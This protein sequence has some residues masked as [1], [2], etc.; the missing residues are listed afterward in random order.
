MAIALPPFC[1]SKYTL[2][3]TSGGG[4]DCEPPLPPTAAENAGEAIIV[5]T[6]FGV[7]GVFILF[8]GIRAF[9]RCRRMRHSR[10]LSSR[11]EQ[12]PAYSLSTLPEYSTAMVVGSLNLAAGDSVALALLAQTLLQP[13]TAALVHRETLSVNED[14]VDR[15]SLK[16]NGEKQEKQHKTARRVS[17]SLQN[18][19]QESKQ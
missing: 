10:S 17:E 12:P 4:Y 7:F 5:G 16:K 1:M 3:P 8:F 18:V 11:V 2:T 14:T 19:G 15:G 6:I 9:I 13:P